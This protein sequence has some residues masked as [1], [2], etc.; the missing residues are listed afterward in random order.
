MPTLLH[1]IH[2]TFSTS[3]FVE[4]KTPKRKDD[5]R[6]LLRTTIDRLSGPLLKKKKK[7]KKME[8]I[9]SPFLGPACAMQLDTLLESH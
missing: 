6:L 7:R 2:L 4:M 1:K 3:V 9:N 8:K 5:I